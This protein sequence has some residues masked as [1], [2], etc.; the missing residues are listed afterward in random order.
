[1]WGLAA[2][3]GLPHPPLVFVGDASQHD[4]FSFGLP[5]QYA[6]ALP[7]GLAVRCRIAALFDPVLRHELTHIR[8]RDV[9]LGWSARAAGWLMIPLQCSN[10]HVSPFVGHTPRIVFEARLS[11]RLVRWLR[12]TVS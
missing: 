6:V 7:P 8:H 5:G 4:A 10:Q 11:K 12:T 3:A 2:E 1:M 9:M